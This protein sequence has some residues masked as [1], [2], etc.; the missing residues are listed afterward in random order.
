MT[1][2]DHPPVSASHPAT[3]GWPLGWRLP[4]AFLYLSGKEIVRKEWPPLAAQLE[5]RLPGVR[6]VAP[7]LLAIL[8][9]ART[10]DTLDSALE[11]GLQLLAA[12]EDPELPL[13]RDLVLLVA[14]CMVERQGEQLVLDSRDPLTRA[15]QERPLLTFPPGLY[16]TSRAVHSLEGNWSLEPADNWSTAALPEVP[17]QRASRGQAPSLPRGR[18]PTIFGR[19][20]EWIPRRRLERA[21]GEALATG[22]C[23]VTGPLGSGKSRLAARVIGGRQGF[24]VLTTSPS[25]SNRPLREGLS[26]GLE[27][28]LDGPA[29]APLQEAADTDSF[30][31]RVDQLSQG[32]PLCLVFDDLQRASAEDHDLL[33][34]LLRLPVAPEQLQ[35]VLIGRTGTRWQERAAQLLTVNVPDLTSDEA[36]LHA[37]RVCEGLEMPQ[38]VMDRFT[39]SAGG[40]PFCFEEGILELIHRRALRRVYGSFFFGAPNDIDLT[41]SPRFV[42]HLLAEGRRSGATYALVALAAAGRALP[43]EALTTVAEE[44]EDPPP[45]SWSTRPPASEWLTE[46]D[47]PWGPAL[48][49][50]AA[51]VRN[52]FDALLVAA[53]RRLVRARLG[54]WLGSHASSDADARWIGYELM[55][56]APGA[57]EVLLQCLKE[58]SSTERREA[59]FAAVCH[60][61]AELRRGGGSESEEVRLLWALLPLARKIGR[62]RD[63]RSELDRARV[64]CEDI[65]EKLLAISTLLAELDLDDGRPREAERSLRRAL[66]I[67]IASDPKRKPLLGVQL[68]RLLQREG[69]LEEARQLLDRLL[70]EIDNPSGAHH[71]P[72]LAATC[73][74]YLGNTA[75]GQRRFRD[76][77]E[78]HR[79]ALQERQRRALNPAIGASLCAVAATHRALGE[80]RQGLELFEAAREHLLHHGREGEVS[81]ALAG[82]ASIRSRLGQPTLATPLLREAVDLRAAHEGTVGE[83]VVRLALAEN[84]LDLEQFGQAQEEARRAHFRLSLI[85][86][87]PHLGRAERLL[88]RI[89]LKQHHGESAR[90][91]FQRACELHR[92][93][94]QDGE[95][96]RDLSWQL[97]EAQERR[98][99]E[100][101]EVLVRRLTDLRETIVQLDRGEL[102]DFRLYVAL[103]WLAERGS[104][105]PAPPL[106]YLRRAYRDLLR[107]T[108]DLEQEARSSFLMQVPEH[109]LIVTAATRHQLSLPDDV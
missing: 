12:V 20:I 7:G 58:S 39:T 88:G 104:E 55:A 82:L 8:A 50:R 62:L 60:E 49:F 106:Q 98:A 71:N 79:A 77:L 107:K 27:H 31:A 65:P 15:M 59:L 9:S 90:Q 85:D 17:L 108:S 80:Y 63:I 99:R 57:T 3:P 43:R 94:G 100:D 54:A 33:A 53:S 45:A 56:G 89:D 68:G 19:S 105:P 48:D 74:F 40:N 6:A 23:R 14:P 35:L 86:Q 2:P 91:H 1:T 81:F 95:L 101:V 78:L 70:E 69:R 16:V 72:G 84:H 22:R 96:A 30:A 34:A 73:R 51:S 109:Q 28:A 29:V 10:A 75:L 83:A 21:L 36:F 44:L 5:D 97:I 61:L 103:D 25:R 38:D 18:N 41:P 42:G 93:Q 13:S 26:D 66:E 64:L 102:L 92:K 32:T 47:S 52:A 76:A 11:F 24:T 87:S 37:A 67:A 4:A 46:C